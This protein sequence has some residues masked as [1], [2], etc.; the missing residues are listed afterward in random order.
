[1]QDLKNTLN[2]EGHEEKIHEGHEEKNREQQH[3][4]DV[5]LKG[6]KRIKF[7]VTKQTI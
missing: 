6:H 1:M 5:F 2:H 7:F 4:R 3:Q